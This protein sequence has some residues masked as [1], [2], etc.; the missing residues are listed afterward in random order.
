MGRRGAVNP[1]MGSPSSVAHGGTYA[2]REW[3]QW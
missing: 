1:W 3:Q 2:G